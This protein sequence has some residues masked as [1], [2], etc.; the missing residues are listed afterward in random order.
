[1]VIGASGFYVWPFNCDASSSSRSTSA[2][3]AS[4]LGLPSDDGLRS[5]I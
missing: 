5:T 3:G 2:R 4:A 1:M